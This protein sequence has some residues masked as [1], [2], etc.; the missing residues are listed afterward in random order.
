M[1]ATR[2]DGD[3]LRQRGAGLA[4]RGSQGS[5][6]VRAM[7]VVLMADGDHLT[8]WA[9]GQYLSGRYV[10]VQVESASEAMGFLSDHEAE[11]VIVSDNLQGGDLDVVLARAVSAVSAD[12]VIKLVPMIEDSRG[13]ETSSVVLLEK[14]FS[15][16]RV[17]ELLD[18]ICGAGSEESGSR[19]P[20]RDG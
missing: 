4:S 17:K 9:L 8:G 10:V 7:P 19:Q 15:L 14:P 12:H 16:E 2:K 18:G 13:P 6:P 11:A 1:S 3:K 20:K 5:V